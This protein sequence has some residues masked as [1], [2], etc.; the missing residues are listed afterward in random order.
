MPGENFERCSGTATTTSTRTHKEI[1]PIAL[2][3]GWGALALTLALLPPISE[4]GLRIFGGTILGLLACGRFLYRATDRY[5]NPVPKNQPTKWQPEEIFQNLD[6]V[7]VTLILT[8]MLLG[9]PPVYAQDQQSRQETSGELKEATKQDKSSSET[10]PESKPAKGSPATVEPEQS[11][12]EQKS[13]QTTGTSNEKPVSSETHRPEAQ[14]KRQKTEAGIPL[15]VDGD[16]VFRIRVKLGPYTPEHRVEAIKN[17][18]K[19]LEESGNFTVQQISTSESSFSTDIVAGETTILT[20]TGLD[21]EADGTGTRQEVA[22]KYATLLRTAL[23]KEIESQSFPNLLLRL[24]LSV[25]ATI[26][27]IALF[28]ISN[29]IFPKLYRGFAS[30]RGKYIR[31]LKFQKAVL[32]PEDSV[33]DIGIGCFRLLR[34]VTVLSVVAVYLTVVL[35]FFPQTRGLANSILQS[36]TGP[37]V[38]VVCPAIVSYAPN[39]LFI[40]TIVV[41]AYYII[42]FT[43]Y[44]FSEIGRGTISFP[45]FDPDWADPTYKIVRFLLIAFAAVLIFPYLPGSGSPA[46]QQISLFLGIL[47]S[48]GS[49]GA[50]AHVIAGVFLTYTGAFKVGDRVKIADT[51]GDVVEK[52]LLATRI[53]TIKQEF[54]TIPNGLVLGSHIINYSSSAA[55]AGLILHSTVTIGYDAPWRQIHQLLIDAALS[56]ESILSEPA[57]FVFQ[58]SLDDFYVSYQINAYTDRPHIMAGTYSQL[59]QNIQDRFNEAGVEIMSPH[60]STLRDGNQTTI[61]VNYLP[62][63]Y[64]VPTFGLRL[65]GFKN[66]L[67]TGGNSREPAESQTIKE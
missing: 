58:T 7:A 55:S 47:V 52:T 60:Y 19:K 25:I 33:I 44:I 39:L 66:M 35:S 46:F 10:S 3:G 26:G 64:E 4:A 14:E 43:R 18:L 65:K 59:H 41:C 32:L 67:G 21:A 50:I 30:L 54:I 61:P 24:G 6:H 49:S 17:R 29:W 57:P 15:V 20:V 48:L 45:A 13:E 36:I 56:T 9:F 51:I 42:S 16:E 40:A 23:E 22:S 28:W 5:I 63:S 37:M 38:T 12:D 11:V 1:V 27:M 62:S 8:V 34:L 53:R 2:S 31:S